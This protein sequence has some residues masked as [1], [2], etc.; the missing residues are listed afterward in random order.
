MIKSSEYHYA[1]YLVEKNIR[2]SIRTKDY[3]WVF[4]RRK[5]FSISLY[6]KSCTY[7]KLYFIVWKFSHKM[8]RKFQSTVTEISKPDINPMYPTIFTCI[9]TDVYDLYETLF[10]LHT[11]CTHRAFQKLCRMYRSHIHI[12]V[13]ECFVG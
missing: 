13:F 2:L 9:N 5:N 7:V 8:K 3:F 1:N 11:T 12:Y 6:R 10:F 4:Y